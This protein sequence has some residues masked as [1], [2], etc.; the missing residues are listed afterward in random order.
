[1]VR[2]I[3]LH[4]HPDT[5]FDKNEPWRFKV[6]YLSVTLALHNTDSLRVVG[7]EV[8]FLWNLDTRFVTT[9]YYSH[10][11]EKMLEYPPTPPPAEGAILQVRILSPYIQ[12]LSQQTRSLQPMLVQRWANV[13]DAGPTLYQQWSCF[14]FAG[15]ALWML[16]WWGVTTAP[17]LPPDKLI[18]KEI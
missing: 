12:W 8:C 10:H 18:A 7:E 14:V 15:F 6:R 5:E 16:T 13:F 11:I 3:R 17:W 1:M 4:C 2:W 9:K